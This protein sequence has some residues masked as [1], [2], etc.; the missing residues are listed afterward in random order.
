MKKLLTA[1]ECPFVS[2][3]DLGVKS[4]VV[5]LV[6]W[7]EDRKIR[8]LEIA[9]RELLK[10]S[11]SFDAA[12]VNYLARLQCPLTYTPASQLACLNWLVGHAIGVE[13][14]DSAEA[15]KDL[16]M[17]GAG[18]GA[19]GA[20]GHRTT[21]STQ[22]LDREVNKLGAL[23]GVDRASSDQGTADY[24]HAIAVKVRS[25]Y[26]ILHIHYTQCTTLYMLHSMYYTIYATLYV[27]YTL[28]AILLATGAHR[29]AS[30]RSHIL[31]LTLHTLYIIAVVLPC[32]PGASV[33]VSGRVGRTEGRGRGSRRHRLLRARLRHAATSS[34]PSIDSAQDAAHLRLQGAPERSQCPHRAGAGV[35]GQPAHQQQARE[36]GQIGSTTRGAGIQLAVSS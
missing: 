22:A 6:S 28:Y 17:T 24:L 9:E 19:T 14:E 23:L 36:G 2:T 33:A 16:E 29:F 25:A 8:E 10:Q 1:L 13:Y 18:A 21:E 20:S 35:H 11:G 15:C 27:R 4:D 12:F 7:L 30:S 5:R 3:V 31:T 34:E 32:C 26:Y